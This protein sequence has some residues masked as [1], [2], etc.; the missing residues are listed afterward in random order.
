[1]LLA[2][3]PL[4]AP[5]SPVLALNYRLHVGINSDSEASKKRK[6]TIPSY[7]F[8]RVSGKPTDWTLHS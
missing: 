3:C 1:M 4:V 8:G 2:D 7:T 5:S 6:P